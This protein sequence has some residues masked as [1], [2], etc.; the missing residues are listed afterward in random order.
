[1]KKRV[2]KKKR[3]AEFKEFGVPVA[4]KRKQKSNFDA[5]LDEFLEQAIES[6]ECCFGGS[7]ND[8]YL[9]GFIELGKATYNPE[10]KLRKIFE[11]LDARPDI[12]KYVTGDLVDAWYGPF[13]EL[14]TI[15]NKVHL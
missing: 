10:E 15:G 5:F 7:G 13:E 8:D 1:M 11:W 2:R 14:D 3:L 9:E 4:I 6:N 12:E